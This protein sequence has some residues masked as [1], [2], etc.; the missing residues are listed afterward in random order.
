MYFCMRVATSAWVK[1]AYHG[2]HKLHIYFGC[3]RLTFYLAAVSKDDQ[4]LPKLFPLRG[5]WYREDGVMDLGR[6]VVENTA[7]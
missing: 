1:P 6:N 7:A 2:Q 5:I 4:R 3:D